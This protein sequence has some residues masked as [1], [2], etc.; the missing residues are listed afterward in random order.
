MPQNADSSPQEI[1]YAPEI[2]EA[3]VTLCWH[4]PEY[5]PKVLRELDPALHIS[6]PPL[7]HLLSAINRVYL[8]EGATDWASVIDCLRDL[9][10]LEQ[11]GD[12]VLLEG[13]YTHPGYHALLDFYIQSLRAYGAARNASPP[14][15][16]HYWSGGKALL[17]PN[18]AKRY[19]NQ[20]DF[21]GS[22][23]IAG[24]FYS[25]AAYSNLDATEVEITFRPK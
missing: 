5:L 16:P 25:L 23:R 1:Y 2:E 12:K 9:G 21:T 8:E 24:K 4:H 11:C 22:G 18:K 19:P 15:N 13:L 17:A 14:Q 3:L 6:A 7:R 20:P 10:L